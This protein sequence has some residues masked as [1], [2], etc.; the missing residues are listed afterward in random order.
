[1]NPLLLTDSY[2]F[3]HHNMYPPGMN[4]MGSYFESRGSKLKSKEV[5]FFGLQYL[6]KKYLMNPITYKDL[7]EAEDMVNLHLGPG[8]FNRGGFRRLVEKYGGML[9]VT[10]KAVPEGT[11]VPCSN[12][13][14]TVESDKEPWLVN[15]LE[16][17]L[18]QMWYPCTVATVSHEIKSLF[19]EFTTSDV[20][21]M[22]HDFGFRGASSVE[23]AALGGAA[24]LLSFRGTDTFVALKML[25]D[26]YNTSMP[27]HS[28]P[29]T[30][31]S[32]ITSWGRNRELEAYRNL[33]TQYPKGMIACVSDSYDIMQACES[34]WG[35]ELKDL[36]LSRDGVLAVR[37]DSGDP[38]KVCSK[39]ASIL[40]EAFGGTVDSRGRKLLN[41]KVRIIQGDGMTPD[42]IRDFLN[43]ITA[44]WSPDNFAF[45]M[46]GG[47]LQRVDR[48]T[49]KFAFKCSWIEEEGEVKEVYK[50]PVGDPGK[51]SKKGKL[52]LVKTPSGF[53]TRSSSNHYEDELP[54][55]LRTVFRDG[56]ILIDEQF[57]T[58]RDRLS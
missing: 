31:H 29:A 57:E 44:E 45:G 51:S 47:L 21:Y 8:I 49:L 50:Q 55:E 16:T 53:E 26:Y 32:T 24:H 30:E 36:V 28:I 23:T 4:A 14:M 15:F 18:V 25:R 20:S 42:S 37:P 46:G 56:R 27:G 33:L 12:V 35:E 19:M 41:P 40:Y 54:D 38:V 17:L 2:K 6:I 34:M 48:D 52:R 58:I 1:M 5:V 10:I 22:L 9:P 13:L 39:V 11:V 43:A 3:S 7:D